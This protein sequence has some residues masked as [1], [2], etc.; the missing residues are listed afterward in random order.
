MGGRCAGKWRGHYSNVHLGENMFLSKP[1]T[2]VQT[3]NS[4]RKYSHYR[5]TAIMDFGTGH[6]WDH[7]S[8]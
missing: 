6:L 1:M 5:V 3:G 8:T 7:H 2:D 4:L